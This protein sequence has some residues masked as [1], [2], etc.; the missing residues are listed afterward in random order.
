MSV[1]LARGSEGDGVSR[2][3]LCCPRKGFFQAH[4]GL[5]SAGRAA[6]GPQ[7]SPH[8]CSSL[9]NAGAGLA[10]EP[11]YLWLPGGAE[12][13]G[14]C[15]RAVRQCMPRGAPSLWV[16]CASLPIE[17]QV[18]AGCQSEAGDEGRVA[19]GPAPMFLL[20]L[21]TFWWHP[22]CRLGR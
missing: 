12:C 9:S 2:A 21:H 14:P 6:P 11:P 16:R 22:L 15:L 18:I 19:S 7:W 4:M 10:A 8:P 17:W 13:G 20:L 5:N 1:D 3:H